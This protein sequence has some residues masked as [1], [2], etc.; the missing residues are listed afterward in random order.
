MGFMA[1]QAVFAGGFMFKKKRSLLFLMARQ[2]LLPGTAGAQFT[3]ARQ[4]AVAAMAVHAAG[5]QFID[6]M[7]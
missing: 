7:P 3:L 6:G 2:A 1:Q 4:A 5:L